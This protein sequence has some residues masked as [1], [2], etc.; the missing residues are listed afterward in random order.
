MLIHF[1]DLNSKIKSAISKAQEN[2]LI[3]QQLKDTQNL[4]A[5]AK[6]TFSLDKFP[7]GSSGCLELIDSSDNLLSEYDIDGL[8]YL[9]E[10]VK[11]VLSL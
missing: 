5:A 9:S 8:K 3:L 6:E 10:S 11:W 7:V 4:I 1:N 2:S